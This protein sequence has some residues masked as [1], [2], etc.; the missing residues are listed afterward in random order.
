MKPAAID[1][2]ICKRC[3]IR[4][5]LTLISPDGAGF[6]ARSFECPKCEHVVIERVATD[7]L[8]TAKGPLSSELKRPE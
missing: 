3:G 7:P 4:T 5:M 1:R 8:E 6:E 2:P